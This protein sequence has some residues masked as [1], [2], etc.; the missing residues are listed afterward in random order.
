MSGRRAAVIGHPIGHS[1][2]PQLH[3]A[4]YAVLGEE[5]AY[6]R[7]DAVP[8]DAEGLAARLRQEPGWVGLSV[9]M[10]MKQAMLAVVDEVSPL[11]R[12]L[13]AVNTVVVRDPEH[14][15]LL[16]T[17]TDVEG[18]RSSLL[19]AA[20]ASQPF[21]GRP[22]LVLGAGGTA[23]A[24]IAALAELEVSRVR[25]AV[26][27]PDRAVDAVQVADRLGVPLEVI[28]LTTVTEL[29]PVPVVV[30][31]LPPRAGDPFASA[32]GQLARPG[33]VLLDAAYDP[34]PSALAAAWEAAGAVAVHGLAMLV[35]QAVGQIEWFTG[36]PEAR[37]P[38]VLTALCDAAGIT[39]QGRAAGSVA[40]W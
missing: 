21:A 28:S 11:A 19:A 8:D 13:G 29:P 30:S 16:G 4:A 33:A 18:V 26:R 27:D 31:T 24:A 7:V 2:S 22:G 36:R 10:P 17:N 14:G 5:I 40:G 23:A 34:W 1:R 3:S 12:T 35:H 9:T 25:L 37:K 32:V 15:G 20:E 6:S 38:A 39:P